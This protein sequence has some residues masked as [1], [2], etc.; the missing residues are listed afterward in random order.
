MTRSTRSVDWLA[1]ASVVVPV[2][3]SCGGGDGGGAR[4]ADLLG[5]LRRVQLDVDE[6]AATVI[7]A[8]TAA[9]LR[10]SS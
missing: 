1:A 7:P 4:D 10:R 3:S 8:S 2:P 5:M 9:S 6:G